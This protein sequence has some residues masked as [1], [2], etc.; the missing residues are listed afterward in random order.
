MQKTNEQ[1]RQN[2]LMYVAFVQLLI[3]SDKT[4]KQD[5]FDVCVP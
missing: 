2:L 3:I 1:W 4:L 5:Q